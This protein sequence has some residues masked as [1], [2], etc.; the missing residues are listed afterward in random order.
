VKQIEP[1]FD[2][3]V[4]EDVAVLRC[5]IHGTV[6]RCP[7]RYMFCEDADPQAIPPSF[8][9]LAWRE[10]EDMIQA[11][12]ERSH[13]RNGEHASAEPTSFAGSKG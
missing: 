5:S 8:D 3:L 7:W 9:S 10:R 4:V 11:A 6:T 2:D 1:I 12:Q 13:A